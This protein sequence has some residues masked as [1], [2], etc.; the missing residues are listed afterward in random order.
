MN[1]NIHISKEAEKD[2]AAAADYIEFTL[3]NPKAAIDL[4]DLIDEKMSKLARSPKAHPVADDL[5]LR[6]LG[7]RFVPIKTYLAFYV[8]DERSKTVHLVRFLYGKRN[9]ISL[10]KNTSSE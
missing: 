1:Y 8:I 3:F 9:W 4:L 6:P 7:I 10:L 5:V 2:I